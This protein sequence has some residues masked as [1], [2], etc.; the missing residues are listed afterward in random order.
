MFS[1]M[2]YLC[3][4]T[5]GANIR[6]DQLAITSFCLLSCLSGPP[7]FQLVNF[8]STISWDTKYNNH[9]TRSWLRFGEKVHSDIILTAA[10]NCIIVDVIFNWKWFLYIL[11]SFKKQ[12]R[13]IYFQYSNSIE[14]FMYQRE[15]GQLLMSS[16]W[17]KTNFILNQE[18]R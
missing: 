2:F 14:I 10:S 18:E 1:S 12:K 9:N 7:T 15:E 13:N 8:W 17:L 16:S 6:I 11:S 5:A 3:W 4:W